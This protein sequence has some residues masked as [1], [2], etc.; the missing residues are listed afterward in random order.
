M[1]SI[2]IA[3]DHAIV[4]EGVKQIISR[5]TQVTAIGE[6]ADGSEVVAQVRSGE[7]NAIVLDLSMPGTNG[8]ELI[9][10][11]K[12]EQPSLSILVLSMHKENQF[13]IRALRAGAS[14]YL[15]K[16][17]APEQL[18]AALEKVLSGGRYITPDVAE[19]IALHLD[20]SI[21]EQ[22]HELLTNR[23]YQ[24][25]RLIASGTSL[26]DIAAELAVSAKTV[27]THKL[28]IMH[29]LNV[30]NTAHLIKYIIEN[31]LA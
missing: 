25:L 23:E 16:E 3:D 15:T 19:R 24:V 20:V 12:I 17:G 7:W 27:S 11:L 18:V 13:A 5:S 9:R 2:L 14:G 8:V 21:K 22:P 31:E 10:R 30:D 28:R 29:K 6:A 26:T 4:R 1:S